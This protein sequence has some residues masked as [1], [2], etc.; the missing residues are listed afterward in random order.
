MQCSTVL[1]GCDTGMNESL[2]CNFFIGKKNCVI[3]G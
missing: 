2:N 3:L 1:E